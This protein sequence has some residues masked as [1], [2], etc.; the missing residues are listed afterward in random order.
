MLS[1]AKLCVSTYDVEVPSGPSGGRR[2][3]DNLR[4]FQQAQTSLVMI[5]PRPAVH[6]R[7]Q[8]RTMLPRERER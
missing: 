1:V 2:A 7:G 5:E 8:E 6:I 3:G 4:V